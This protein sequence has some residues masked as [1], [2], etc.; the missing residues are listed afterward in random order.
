LFDRGKDAGLSGEFI[1]H[2]AVE[3]RSKNGNPRGRPALVGG[4]AEAAART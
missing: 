3:A 4:L 1:L 2:Q